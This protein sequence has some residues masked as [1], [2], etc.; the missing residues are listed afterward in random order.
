MMAVLDNPA[1]WMALS[2]VLVAGV[3]GFWAWYAA[4]PRAEMD[5]QA[6]MLA[7][8]T[9]L[10]AE[11]KEERKSLIARLAAAER[12]INELEMLLIKS[13]IPFGSVPPQS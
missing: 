12:R 4:R 1:L 2:A 13:G 11:F 10:L 9:A 5:A 7:G 8:F 6:S 3:S